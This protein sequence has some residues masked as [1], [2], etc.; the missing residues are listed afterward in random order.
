[1]HLTLLRCNFNG[2]YFLSPFEKAKIN[3][4]V[5]FFP[6]RGVGGV[7]VLF[8]RVANALLCSYPTL[9]ISLIDYPDGYMASNAA[10]KRLEI[11]PLIPGQKIAIPND[12]V[13]IMQSL[14]LWRIPLEISFG[15]E[16]RLLLWHLHPFNIVPGAHWLW[17][18]QKS[19]SLQL[20]MRKALFSVQRRKLR[21]LIEECQHHHGIVFMDQANCDGV[22]LATGACI[23][24]PVFVPVPSSDVA[25]EQPTRHVPSVPLHCAWVGRLEDFKIPILTYTLARVAEYAVLRNRPIVFHVVGAGSQAAE[26]ALLG[27]HLKNRIFS[28]ICHGAIPLEQL[29]TFLIE[30]IDLLFAMG[31]AALEGAKLAIPVAL[32][33]FSYSPLNGDYIYH[34]L[35]DSRNYTLGSPITD[36]NYSQGNSSLESMLDDLINSYPELSNKTRSYFIEHHSVESVLKLFVSAVC[37]TKF[38]FG[39]VIKLKLA[40]LDLPM[41]IIYLLR[42][43]FS[44]FEYRISSK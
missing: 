18:K 21:N 2:E 44:G 5:F 16:T 11:I 40:C 20:L 36:A 8:L 33:D 22:K 10:D 37:N 6:Y 42:H 39:T 30:N 43:M 29:D 3:K 19:L 9:C 25:F 15:P 12:S 4:I 1:V 7:P 32:L 13:C 41:R 14:P 26:I 34:Y 23:D 38:T 35:F 31:T 17:P 28:V 24:A 27:E